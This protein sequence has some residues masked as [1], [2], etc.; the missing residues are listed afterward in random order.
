FQQQ[1]KVVAD[2]RRHR[3]GTSLVRKARKAKG[4]LAALGGAVD[5]EASG[6]HG[7]DPRGGDLAMAGLARTVR[8]RVDLFDGV[9]DVDQVGGERRRQRLRLAPLRRHLAG[10]GEVWVVRQALV[11]IAQLLQLTSE[12]SSLRFEF[13]AQRARRSCL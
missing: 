3:D 4:A 8:T 7:L 9:L 12:R 6:R 5:A 1:W 11:A 10:I 2:V 13:L